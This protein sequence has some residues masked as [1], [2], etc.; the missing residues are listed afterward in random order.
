MDHISGLC[1]LTSQSN[2]KHITG[3]SSSSG[4]SF[5]AGSS[6]EPAGEGASSSKNGSLPMDT[7]QEKADEDSGGVSSTNSN[8][9]DKNVNGEVV[10]HFM[11]ITMVY[12]HQI[13]VLQQ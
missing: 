1:V 7:A 11:W 13:N 4:L 5:A 12:Y 6:S 10:Q 8:E 9:E 2:N 3:A